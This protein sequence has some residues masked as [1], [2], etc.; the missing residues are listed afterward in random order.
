MHAVGP[1]NTEDVIDRRRIGHRSR[2]IG[3]RKEIRLALA[4]GRHQGAVG[5]GIDM[6]DGGVAVGMGA[7]PYESFAV[8]VGRWGR[9]RSVGVF[10]AVGSLRVWHSR[11]Y[12]LRET[13]RQRQ[14]PVG[15]Q[16]IGEAAPFRGE[17][18]HAAWRHAAAESFCM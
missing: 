13:R 1:G 14:F 11:E 15:R 9:G 8:E 5:G 17:R 7:E 16:V 4:V 10:P 18:H 12:G 6:G 2:L 3:K